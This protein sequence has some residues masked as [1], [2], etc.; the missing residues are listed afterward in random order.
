MTTFPGPI[1]SNE[2][3]L[4]EAKHTNHKSVKDLTIHVLSAHFNNK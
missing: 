2:G 4:T 3:T 1:A